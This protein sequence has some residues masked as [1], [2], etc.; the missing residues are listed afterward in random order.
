MKTQILFQENQFEALKRL[1]KEQEF[2]RIF[3]VRGDKSYENSGAETFIKK[4]S[5]KI[6]IVS[7]SNFDVNPNVSD[8]RRGVNKFNYGQEVLNIDIFDEKT[9]KT[10]L[11]KFL[12]SRSL[13]FVNDYFKNESNAVLD[14]FAQRSFFDLILA[15]GGGS[16]LDMAKLI[17]VFANQSGDF[18]DIIQNN[19][20]EGIIKTPLLAIPTTAGTGAEATHF[21]V[22]Y[23]GK[24]KYSVAAKSIL[25]D[26]VY[27]SSEFS[28][29]A[30][31]Y[32]TACTGLDAFSQAIE[33]VWSVSSTKESELYALKAIEIIWKNIAKAVNNNDRIAKS[34]MQEAA[35][36]AGK[37]INI[38]KTTAPHAIS[39]TFTSYYGIPHGHAVS[40]SLPY[41]IK[42]NYN[43]VEEDC[44]DNR[45]FMS[46]KNR[47]DKILNILDLNIMEVEEALIKFF[48]L[49]GIEINI[50]KLI[51]KFDKELIINNV[52]T[53]RLN[54]NPRM[55]TKETINSFI[56]KSIKY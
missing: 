1:L 4:L 35:F 24:N 22:I 9:F 44:T 20:I 47:I 19:R 38:T 49:L 18:E 26:Y 37:A 29:S 28:A 51:Q 10:K 13:H 46:V 25:P 16:V 30:K 36:L 21:A 42:Y 14:V 34:A 8:L 48:E 39:Y 3:L 17:S 32:L 53:E 27:L 54:N 55:V 45:G 41:F 50:D 31:S 40:L 56:E 15:I 12:K 7:F 11:L 43:L 23:I 33:S 6:E 2:K 52:N 5:E